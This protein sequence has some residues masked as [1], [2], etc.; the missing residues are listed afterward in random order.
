MGSTNPRSENPLKFFEIDG[1]KALRLKIQHKMRE[2]NSDYEGIRVDLRVLK[3]ER[4]RGKELPVESES[5]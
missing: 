5:E 1:E 3:F 4:K 2:S